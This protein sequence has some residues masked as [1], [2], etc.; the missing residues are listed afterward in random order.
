MKFGV[1]VSQSGMSW[2][3][4]LSIV[5]WLDRESGFERLWL[6]DHFVTGTGTAFGSEGA[7]F[8]AWTSL[9]AV[10]M[11][12]SRLRL[13][14]L[15]SGNTYRHPAVLA[16]MA[17]TVDHIS[18]GRLDFG[19]GAAWHEY[20][21]QAFGIP[22]PRVKE[23]LDRLDEAAK[24]IKLLWTQDRPQFE[25]TY[26]QLDAPPY[27]PSNVQVP[28]PPILIG[29][30]GEKRTLKIVARYADIANISYNHASAATVKH[31]FDVLD[32]HCADLGRDPATILRTVQKLVFLTEDKAVHERAIIGLKAMGNQT[33]DEIRSTVILG[34][35][36]EAKSQ[37]QALA[38]AGVEET[39]IVQF[40]PSRRRTLEDFSAGVIPEFS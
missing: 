12:T 20:E 6:A 13:G 18:N 37:I 36:E 30:N 9:A 27:N 1:Q 16:K 24:V 35:V 29:G 4:F 28:H 14:V 11:A 15:V 22:F 25:G 21:H 40:D 3:D 7:Y 5:E 8:E 2:S 19:L 38:D 10:A 34:G 26:Y 32:R 17:T 31:K 23:R 39:Y 33:E